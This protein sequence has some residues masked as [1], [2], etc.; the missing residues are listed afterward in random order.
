MYIPGEVLA[1]LGIDPDAPPPYFRVWP[2]PRRKHPTVLVQFY[3][4]R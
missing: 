2:G 3:A 1:S 4:E